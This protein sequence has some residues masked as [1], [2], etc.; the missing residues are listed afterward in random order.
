MD[1]LTS[2]KIEKRTKS[3]ERSVA[4]AETGSGNNKDDL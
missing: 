3:V 2:S 1:A 4:G